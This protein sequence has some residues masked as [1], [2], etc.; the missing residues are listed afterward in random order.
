MPN[1]RRDVF[2]TGV[3]DTMNGDSIL[4]GSGILLII[5]AVWFAVYYW[6]T[7]HLTEPDGQARVVGTCGDVMEIR[8][9]FKDGRMV[10]GSAWTNGCALSFNCVWAAVDLAEGKSPEEILDIDSA[11]IR[12]AVGGLPEDHRHCARLAIDT[13]YAAID[14][15][16]K[17]ASG[18]CRR[19]CT[20]Y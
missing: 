1:R 12:D 18:S 8:L 11:M 4:L 10:D 6:I 15:Y 9:K 13:L 2:H 3:D 17:A 20:G 5:T 19:Y 14:N 7:P 16:M